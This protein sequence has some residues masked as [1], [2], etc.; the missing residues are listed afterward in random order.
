MFITPDDG[1]RIVEELHA[2]VGWDV[3][4]MDRSGIIIASSNP[5]RIGQPHATAQ[6]LIREHLPVLEVTAAEARDGM[7]EG[8]NLP[9]QVDGVC[10]GVIGIT[11][12]CSAVREFGKIA[13]KMTEILLLT[14]RQETQ[15]AQRN[16]ARRLFL[17]AWLFDR[18]P[19]WQ[20]FALRGSLL[21]LDI[22]QPH[23]LAVL[24]PGNGADWS[25]L[26]RTRLLQH[27]EGLLRRRTDIVHAV[28]NGRLLLLFEGEAAGLAQPLLQSVLDACRQMGQILLAGLS[29]AVTRC[30]AL[31]GCYAEA[32]MA[33]ATATADCPIRVYSST[34]LEF[35]LRSIDATVQRDVVRAVLGAL[36]KQ[37]AEE[38]VAYLRLY[39]DCDGNIERAAERACVHKN[40]FRYHMSKIARA[41]GCSIQQPSG[42]VMLYLILKFYE[43]LRNTPQHSYLQK[44]QSMQRF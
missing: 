43:N 31:P 38:A 29:S 18:E 12:P 30:E 44:F 14:R 26:T 24:M 4:I 22:H 10:E 25:E 37:E 15:E 16:Q 23:C 39:F 1:R 20:A 9:I 17:E 11:G 27:M 19:D 21:N 7:Q 2:S 34:S 40:T 32:K 3:N 28:V 8:V 41:T 33:A 42:L 35:I 5:H 36:P 6:R 13:K